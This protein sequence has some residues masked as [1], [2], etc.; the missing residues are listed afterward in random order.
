[1]SSRIHRGL[2]A[3]AL[4]AAPFS[5]GVAPVAAQEISAVKGGL[6]GVI[7]DASGAAVPNARV[8]FTGDADKRT[9]T[10]DAAGDYSIG[11][12]T[13]GLYTVTAELEGFQT[14]QVKAVQ[15][16][17]S[18]LSTLN[19]KL[20][21]GAV[22]DTVTVD[23]NAVQIETTST[24]IGS[25][26]DATFYSQVPVAR[27]VGSLFYTAPGATN[28][29]GTGTAN[30]S[31]GGA[32][33]L[34]NQ[35]IIDGVNLTD[36]GY[37]GLGVFSPTYGS[38]GT[39]INLTFIQEVQVKE[40]ALEPKYGKANGGVAL[41]VTKSGGSAYHGAISAYV[42][43]EQFSATQRYADNY[44]NRVNTHGRIYAKPAFDA[45]VELGGYVPH[46]KDHL[47][48]YGA[49]NP[50][51]NQTSFVAPAGIGLAAHGPFSN[52]IT[53]YGWAGKLTYK[54]NDKATLEG[55]AFGDPSSSN[56]GFGP[57]NEDTFPLYPNI[58]LANTTPFSRW[59]FGSR[60]EVARL[61][62]VPSATWTVNLAATAKQS[63][64]DETGFTN[65]YAITSTVNTAIDPTTNRPYGPQFTA[66]GLGFVQNPDTHSYTGAFDTEKVL[67]LGRFGSHSLSIGYEF[68][69]AIYD[70]T[71]FYTGPNYTIPTTND[72]GTPTDGA[73]AGRS[74][75]AAFRLAPAINGAGANTCPLTICPYVNMT[76]SDGSTRRMAVYLLQTRGIY[77]SPQAF[78]SVSYHQIYG[79]DD[80]TIGRRVTLNAGIRWDEEQLNGVIQQYVFNDNWSPRVGIN[81]D[82]FGDRKS[83][84]FFN[85][86]RYTQALPADAAVREL[87]QESDI[88]R[89]TF[90]PAANPDGSL[91]LSANGTA[92]PILDAAH[93]LSGNAAAGARAGASLSYSGG[94][95]ELIAS[96]TKLN[97]EEEFVGGFERALPGGFVLSARY[98]DRR[99]TRILE[100]LSGVSPEGANGG[101]NQQFLIG[102]PNASADYFTNE[103]ERTY[104]PDAAGNPPAD[105]ALDYGEQLDSAG[106]SLGFACGLN[107][108]VAGI[109]VPDGKSDGFAN[110]RRHYQSFEIEANK[111]FSHNFLVR[112]NYRFA[113]L[114]G[115]YEGL[116]RNDNGQSDPGVSSL[117]DFTQ[118][119]LGELG[120]QFTPGYLNTDRRQVG[121]LYGSYVVPKSFLKNLT[122]GIGIRGASGTPITNLGA[123][124]VYGNAGE[125]PIGGR[126]GLGRIASN[127]T[128]DLHADFPINFS[129]TKRLKLTWD[130]FNVTNSRSL[131]SIDQD[132]ALNNTTVNA[133]FLKPLAFQRAFY[134]R[135]AVRFEF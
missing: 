54:I 30:P 93:F 55:S 7:T 101:L 43:P 126:G 85:F 121:N 117:F 6:Q 106:N 26:L 128:L 123:H 82:P 83:K 3:A 38:L 15:V 99:L 108:D 34:E 27:N 87:N 75:N 115:N 12:L 90:A 53:T 131:V 4:F 1:M 113:K 74:S 49:F 80:W 25:N 70:L 51:L 11:G 97:L 37:G 76:N 42:A 110:P 56:F 47:F 132:S 18:R 32:T 2:F 44:F 95:P 21:L 119:I 46:F 48:F 64:F 102:N 45:A 28:G 10:A 104:T 50:S 33:G 78:T 98:T 129:D 58:N 96:G 100:D 68:D 84:I 114:Y 73:V 127:Y 60:S 14:T 62:A 135:G 41:I 52:A 22:S 134:A 86:A 35:Y 20:T 120:G 16:A 59:S 112:V 107:P 103:Q 66:Q 29:G 91:A 24:A 111:N 124:P 19:L 125:I 71:K 92:I 109:T 77:S 130:T 89:A 133:D 81:I 36:V 57:A 69:R 67:K 65:D 23:A 61:N 63:H 72:I 116:Y 105:C 8:T 13:P 40:G 118:G 31:I 17:V 5:A 79:N 9:V 39:G 122:G 94:A 88:N